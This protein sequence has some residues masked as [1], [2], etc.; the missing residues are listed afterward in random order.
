MLVEELL[1]VVPRFREN[2]K[3][4]ITW[5]RVSESDLPKDFVSLPIGVHE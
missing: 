5:Q 4:E 3:S 1:R 2:G